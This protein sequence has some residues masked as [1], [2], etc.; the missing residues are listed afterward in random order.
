MDLLKMRIKLAK[1]G[2]PVFPLKLSES[3]LLIKALKDFTSLNS[4]K[5]RAIL[6][7]IDQPLTTKCFLYL[8]WMYMSSKFKNLGEPDLKDYLRA[9]LN[10]YYRKL[11][12]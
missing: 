11:Y 6:T 7:L 10:H 8:V 2:R 12:S 3:D 4:N 5:R 9:K 1:D